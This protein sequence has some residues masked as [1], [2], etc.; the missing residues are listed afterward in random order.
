MQAYSNLNTINMKIA[1]FI[2]DNKMKE[3]NINAVNV[4]V[5][6]IENEKVTGVE[7]ETLYNKNHNYISLWLINREVNEVYIQYTDNQFKILLENIN[8]VVNHM[9][10]YD[11]P[12]KI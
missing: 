7:N 11:Y 10:A 5:F 9:K 12:L 2:N 8:I 4:F 1:I 3:L 6:T